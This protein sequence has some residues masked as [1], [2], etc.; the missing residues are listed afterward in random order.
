MENKRLPLLNVNLRWFILAMILANIAGQMAYSMMSLYLISLGANVGQVGMVYTLASLIPIVLQIF[1]GWLSDTIGRLRAIAIGS[2][3]S[4]FGYLFFVISPSWQWVLLGLT[5]EYISSSF[6][7]P[8]FSSYIAEQSDAAN[9]GK[10]YGLSS[11]I[12][13]VVT[14]IGP[15]LAGFLAY[16][17]NFRAMLLAAFGFYFLATLVRVWMA[18]S[19]RFKASHKDGIPTLRGLTTQLKAIFIL[20]TAGGV[21]TWVWI[22]DAIGDTSFNLT[23]NLFPIYLSKI[24]HLTVEQIGLLGSAWGLASIAGSFLGGWLVDKRSE[25]TVLAGGFLLVAISLGVMMIARDQ[26]VFLLSRLLNGLGEGIL[27]PSYNSLISKVVPEE[28]RG[29]A[30]GF[31][32]TSLGILSL[33]MPWIGARLWEGFT[34]QT[35]FWI[36][37]AFCLV[38]VPIAW[39]KFVLPKNTASEAAP[40]LD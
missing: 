10:V 6:V 28:K 31:L 30:F 38:T 22:T 18:F 8:S 25:R 20:L 1:G 13:M 26:A 14:V 9:R 40:Q 32:G 29:L 5:V 24:G 2:G 3:I 33:P 23:A 19:E 15:A 34:P 11:G 7:A 12:Y 37:A 17:Y 27:M 4:V 21:L 39:F 35:P 36:T 16:R